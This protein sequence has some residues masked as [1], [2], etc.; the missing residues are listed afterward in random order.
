MKRKTKVYSSVQAAEV[1]GVGYKRVRTIIAKGYVT[2]SIPA[3]KTGS[4]AVWERNELCKLAIFIRL[5]DSGITEKKAA[6]VLEN[7]RRNE[8]LIRWGDDKTFAC[9][10][11]LTVL[12]QELTDKVCDYWDAK[13]KAK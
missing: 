5:V 2:P 13:K 1:I 6:Q 4:A 3:A 11:N 12:R 7:Y 10:V 8:T 9:I